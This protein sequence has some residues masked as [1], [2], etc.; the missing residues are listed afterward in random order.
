MPLIPKGQLRRIARRIADRLEAQI[1]H[2]DADRPVDIAPYLPKGIQHQEEVDV[3]LERLGK[4]GWVCF[5]SAAVTGGASAEAKA[6]RQERRRRAAER[7]Q[8]RLGGQIA[9]DLVAPR[10]RQ[11]YLHIGPTNSGKT[12]DALQR[13]ARSRRGL[14]LAPLRLLAWEAA[15]R[16]NE[17]GCPTDL[18]TGEEYVPVEGARVVSATTEMFPQDVYEV[19]VIDEAQ[20][21][22][23]PDRGWAWLRALVRANASELHVCAAPQAEEFLLKLFATLGD[24]VSVR[25]HERLVP[26]RPLP[27]AVSLDRLPE[28]SAVVAFS[29]N[30]VLQLKAE[31]EA[32][33]KKPCAVIYGAL[34]PD[35]RREQARRVRSGECPFVAATDAIG[36]GINFPVDHVFIMEMSKYDGK[37]DRPLRADEVLQIIGRAGRF[38]LS[39][40]GW[41]G[42]AS[43]TNH[44]LLLETAAER[45]LPVVSAYLQPTV[46]HLMLM[47]G[48]L[49]KRLQLWQQLAEPLVPEFVKIAPL[50]Q[51]IELAKLLPPRL[52]ENLEEAYMLITAPVGRD[53]Q[54]YWQ[55]V[56]TALDAGRKAPAPEHPP[57]QIHTATDLQAAEGALRQHE[58]CLW[59]IRRGV[60]FRVGEHRVRRNRNA[61]ADAMNEALARGMSLGGCRICGRKLP[62]G[63]RFRLCRSCFEARTGRVDRSTLPGERP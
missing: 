26:L 59:L 52:E 57:A 42:S 16:L 60:S 63:Y 55:A 30:G 53:S 22:G 6:A 48:R 2:S 54:A 13:L 1:N 15:E 11:V 34:P 14:Y 50:E 37:M 33:H 21:V 18:L 36:M 24:E 17:G 43:R 62:P 41:Y 9:V 40:A 45:P 51:M 28:R 46:E 20:M 44:Q 25:H 58:L 8:D 7:V 10:R 27:D 38:G 29:R 4:L 31:I 56:V 32:I 12:H 5:S 49:H 23:D 19:V 47:K 39:E 35:V 3:V 61:I